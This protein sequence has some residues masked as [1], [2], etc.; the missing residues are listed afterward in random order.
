MAA[1][2]LLCLPASQA[3]VAP[4]ELEFDVPAGLLSTA[5]IEI[6]RLGGVIV[7][8]KPEL[9]STRSAGP[10]QGRLSLREALERALH[11]TDLSIDIKTDGTVTVREPSLSATGESATLPT[12]Q[13]SASADDPPD[14][15]LL[16]VSA[17]TATRTETV[18]SRLPQS[19][20]V[21]TR[22]ALDLQNAQTSTDGLI[23]IP[24]VT[25]EIHDVT[26]DMMPSLTIRGFPALYLISGM[27]TLRDELPL[28]S[29][30]LERIEVLKGPSGVI[31]GAADSWGRGGTI[32]LI[33]KQAGPDHRNTV[34]LGLSS[35]D[36]GTLRS[37][38]DLGAP[39]APETHWRLVGHGTRSGHT[40]GGYDGQHSRGLLGT[41]SYRGRDL[42]ATL[43]V[44]GDRRRD[45]PAATSR[46]FLSPDTLHATGLGDEVSAV[47]SD[48]WTRSNAGDIELD[49]SW[50]F[51][52]KWRTLLKVRRETVRRDTR[53]HSFA[54]GSM[55]LLSL[56]RESSRFSGLQ[57]GVI[58]DVAT[59]AVKHQLLLAVDVGRSRSAERYGTATWRI[60][61]ATFQPGLTVLPEMPIWDGLALK[62]GAERH[63][64]RRGLLLQDQL[65]WGNWGAG[66]KVQQSRQSE[67]VV[68]GEAE[69]STT[70]WPKALN[71]D[72]G[73]AY[74]LT[75]F[76]A[77]YGGWQSTVAWNAGSNEPVLLFDGSEAH[78]T[79]MRQVQA[80]VK[81]DLLDDRL[82]LTLEAFRLQLLNVRASSAEWGGLFEHPGRDVR[83]LEI[84]MNGHVVP[85]LEM[86]LGL[87]L[88]RVR[89]V[90]TGVTV[91]ATQLSSVPGVGISSRTLNLLA[92]Y[93]L[94]ETVAPASSVGLAFR[95]FSPIWATAP[96][97]EG[98]SAPMRLPGGARTD[99]SWT[100]KTGSWTF[101]VFIQ[102]VFD[103]KLYGTFASQTYVPL[104]PGRSL[105]VTLTVGE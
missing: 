92:R 45:V 20:S 70:S 4:R 105:G 95:A 11:D 60:D 47:S 82:A 21:V 75:P 6:G 79:R 94:P 68:A 50:S 40:E 3:A 39:L 25:G 89:D 56:R 103:R 99:L 65:S 27:R 80:G 102:N 69:D 61:P 98:L 97:A 53:R 26:S 52:P 104:Q 24:G 37:S 17:S 74:Q 10:I 64:L 72:A 51:A 59:G 73:L 96:D 7:S 44:Q 67:R 54:S 90:A 88:V 46:V 5:L 101:G 35:R 38:F 15:G 81:F 41:V 83:G 19:V 33:R 13:V 57:T 93:H 2:V 63:A 12:V 71:W 77:V 8:F 34:A 48:D 100:R 85:A 42:Q 1:M 16:A 91:P 55:V 87:A 78:E 18:L 49:L 43:T 86:N 31:G 76:T 22:E 62:P 9:V 28:D 32:N 36:N 14:T 58:G 23:Y 66:V 29:E 30:T 84:E